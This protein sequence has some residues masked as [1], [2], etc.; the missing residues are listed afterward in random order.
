MCCPVSFSGGDMAIPK[1][2][3]YMLEYTAKTIESILSA[4]AINGQEVEVDVYNRSD[5]NE[6]TTGTGRRLK[7]EDDQFLVC[8][9]I[10]NGVNEDYWSYNIVRESASRARKT[11]R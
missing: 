3:A 2:P 7:D 10:S 11:K 1:P 9:S 5:M 6:R 8:V 4:A